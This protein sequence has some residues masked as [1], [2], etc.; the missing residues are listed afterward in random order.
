MDDGT[1]KDCVYLQAPE[2]NI[3]SRTQGNEKSGMEMCGCDSAQG[4]ITV[5]RCNQSRL[6]EGGGQDLTERV[7]VQG[8]GPGLRRIPVEGLGSPPLNIPGLQWRTSSVLRAPLSQP[9]PI[10]P[11]R[12]WYQSLVLQS[13]Q[14]QQWLPLGFGSLFSV[15]NLALSITQS[16]RICPF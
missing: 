6:L 14:E 3:K 2:K 13:D 7:H 11:R 4:E 9:L 15:I 1:G 10:C 16:F 8:I 5:D 12:T